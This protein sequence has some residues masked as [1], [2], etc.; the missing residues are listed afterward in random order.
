MSVSNIDK[1]DVSE[2]FLF[3]NVTNLERLKSAIKK[4][5]VK[6]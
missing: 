1:F 6:F 3:L 5:N 4:V 2:Y